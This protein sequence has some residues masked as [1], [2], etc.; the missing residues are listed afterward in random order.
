MATSET[1]PASFLHLSASPVMALL[2]KII[3][4]QGVVNKNVWPHCVNSPSQ[5]VNG[6]KVLKSPSYSPRGPEP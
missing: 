1:A 5:S 3:G 2:L 4:R 6:T